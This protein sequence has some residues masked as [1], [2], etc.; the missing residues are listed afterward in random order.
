MSRG[1]RVALA[2]ACSL[3]AIGFAT[4]G[5]LYGDVFPKG[6]W[7]FYGLAGFCALIAL[8]CLEPAS[9]PIALRFIG[10]VVC[11]AFALYLYDSSGGP[12]FWRARTGFGVLGLPAGYVAL[13]GKY[14]R[15]GKGAKAFGVSPSPHEDRELPSL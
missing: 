5:A 9:R 2:V 1:G 3:I 8:A 11:G 14:P 12:D 13:T 4:V 10:A 6:P 7:P 15:W